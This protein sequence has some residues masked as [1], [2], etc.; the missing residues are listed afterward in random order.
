MYVQRTTDISLWTIH[1]TPRL[2]EDVCPI[3][4]HSVIRHVSFAEIRHTRRTVDQL[5]S[6][7]FTSCYCSQ[8][9]SVSA[10]S[11]VSLISII[12]ERNLLFLFSV[13]G[14]LLDSLTHPLTLRRLMLSFSLLLT[15]SIETCDPFQKAALAAAVWSPAAASST[16]AAAASSAASPSPAAAAHAAAAAAAAAAASSS[17][18][19]PAAHHPPPPPS[20]YSHGYRAVSSGPLGPRVARDPVQRQGDF[21]VVLTA[22]W[23]SVPP[24]PPKRPSSLSQ[25]RHGQVGGLGPG[26]LD[27]RDGG[28]HE[29]PAARLRWRRRRSWRGRDGGRTS[30]VTPL[31]LLHVERGRGREKSGVD[32]LKYV[33]QGCA[34]TRP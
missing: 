6:V 3:I 1:F 20:G 24:S 18:S 14:G 10:Q 32:R 22:G 28:A 21:L 25:G 19:P 4:P 23:E 34:I 31:G 13:G 26:P 8:F 11:L 7:L 12:Y 16:G 2:R 27:V 15:P 29:Q 33:T 30:L 9:A 5:V 17:P